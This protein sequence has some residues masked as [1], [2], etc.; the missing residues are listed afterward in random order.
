M[1][2][3]LEHGI[4]HLP[5]ELLALTLEMG[6]HLRY[7]R[8]AL[9]MS[10]VSR[11]FRQVALRTPLL[12]T[13]FSGDYSDDQIQAFISRSGHLNL[14]ISSHMYGP[15]MLS[16]LLPLSS[17]WSSIPRIDENTESWIDS[18][19]VSNLP[20]LKSSNID[21]SWDIELPMHRM[22]M[23][24]QIEG[25]G[26]YFTVPVP[27][28]SQLTSVKIRFDRSREL[29]V[30]KFARAIY[31]LS[32][33]RDLSLDISNPGDW[34]DKHPLNP[35][36]ILH[37]HS[38]PIESLQISIWG[39]TS[40]KR[41]QPLYDCLG[42]LAPSSVQISLSM[43][44]SR[45]HVNPF[46]CNSRNQLFPYGTTIRLRIEQACDICLI[47]AQ[48]L[49]RCSV[50]RSVHLEVPT[51][52]FRI[53][54]W[55]SSV[56]LKTSSISLRHLRLQNCEELRE[57]DVEGL[58]KYLLSCHEEIGVQSLQIVACKKIHMEPFLNLDEEIAKKITWSF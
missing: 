19:G 54:A 9:S 25:F 8:F 14:E 17:R 46:L 10:H 41:I 45:E 38:V 47:L 11:R 55:P 44:T 31:Q 49:W 3:I 27:Y 13:R 24:S 22:P 15:Q 16:Y 33:L 32:N 4:I 35:M 58:A 48:L 51:A 39:I 42:Y 30:G 29:E 52:L 26:L 40:L 53:D 18:V 7:D 37:P 2:L 57:E 36:E 21:S 43:I 34:D 28:R 1:P 20:R 56:W 5:D 12:W 23:L 50:V 6:H